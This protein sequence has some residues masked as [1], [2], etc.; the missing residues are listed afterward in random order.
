MCADD[1]KLVVS[2]RRWCGGR[3]GAWV[4]PDQAARPFVQLERPGWAGS[5]RGTSIAEC[6]RVGARLVRLECSS[7]GSRVLRTRCMS[8]R[9]PHCAGYAVRTGTGPATAR[10]R[11]ALRRAGRAGPRLGLSGSGRTIQGT[12]LAAVLTVPVA[13]R[14]YLATVEAAGELRRHA[15]DCVATWLRSS[16]PGLVGVG[17]L[18]I[19]HPAGDGPDAAPH[20]HVEVLLPAWGVDATGRLRGIRRKRTQ[21]ELRELARAWRNVLMTACDAFGVA[22]TDVRWAGTSAD[23]DDDDDHDHH[24]DTDDEHAVVHWLWRSGRK[25]VHR[26][27]YALRPWGDWRMGA[28][29]RV[30]WWGSLGPA[31]RDE[32]RSLLRTLA[33]ERAPTCPS[34]GGDERCTGHVARSELADRLYQVKVGADGQ[35]SMVPRRDFI[36]VE[37]WQWVAGEAEALAREKLSTRPGA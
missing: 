20:V 16:D 21:L 11:V 15:R 28:A 31:A 37:A 10:S 35:R 17:G 14:P 23:R 5:K 18:A 30:S 32:L 7:C 36:G 8:G 6:P 12:I 27:R 4:D 33:P 34:C 29:A 19:V 24:P 9:C 26:L 2:R 1:E 13:L 3:A 22:P 25:A